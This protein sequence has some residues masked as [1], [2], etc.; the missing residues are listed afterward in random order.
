[1]YQERTYRARHQE[2]G[3]VQYQVVV[4]ETDLWISAD[5]DL[6]AEITQWVS[7]FRQQI[8]D[9]EVEYPGFIKSLEPLAGSSEVPLIDRM[10]NASAL[11]GVGPMAAVA[12]GISQA[13]GERMREA[14]H[15]RNLCIENGGD[16]YMDS[17]EDRTILIYAGSS[18]LSEKIGL[19]LRRDQFPLGICTSAGTVGH[20]LSFGKA[21]AAVIL[22]RNAFLA[23]AVATA[24]GNH[25]K[26]PADME[27][28]LAFIRS[29]P[30]I[31]GCVLIIGEHLGAWGDL[32]LVQI[33]R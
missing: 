11:A 3:R 13:V 28:T 29:I 10:L 19:R 7:A 26:T 18:P 6:T 21:D 25:L 16:I 8:L 15:S 30:G 17:E 14:G 22:A 31:M 24:A 20:S 33:E 4:E 23:D 2:N 32:E 9:A 1:M 27:R 12:G 5:R